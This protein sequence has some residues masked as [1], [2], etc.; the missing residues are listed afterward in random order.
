[1]SKKLSFVIPCYKSEKTIGKVIEEIRKTVKVGTDYEII[2][3]NDSSPDNLERV[4]NDLVDKYDN[5]KV[6]HLARNFG[7]HN[8]LMAGYKYVTGDIVISIDDD[9]QTPAEECYKLIDA[10]NESY[11]VVY[12]R[13][14]NKQHS[15]FKN[16]GSKMATL[17]GRMLLNVPRD[18]YV[19]SYFV[20]KKYVIDEII[21]YENPYPYL[22]GLI[23]RTTR[24]VKNVDIN[25]RARE[26][27]QTSYTFT[28]LLSLWLNGFTAFSVKPLR[29]S[30]LVGALSSFC[31][32]VYG[33]YI[34]V[35]KM[36]FNSVAPTGYSSL[37]SVLLFIGGMIMLM[38]G[39]VGEYIG[40]VYISINNAPQ[41]VIRRKLNFK[42][43]ENE[44][45]QKD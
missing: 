20:C 42:E 1:M 23:L 30:T 6:I 29:I 34:V 14:K 41:Y 32:F 40:R 22:C 10:L 45:I 5:L 35:R 37:M 13:Y 19:S 31:G 27:G 28:K 2:C 3:V 43:K 36:F 26:V 9:G 24:R 18:L 38:L 8:A 7:Q 39:L 21:K 25:H 12:A 44:K 16:F 17:M 33:I 11:D 15:K 4:L